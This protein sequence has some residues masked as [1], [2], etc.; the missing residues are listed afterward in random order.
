MLEGY[1][2]EK[3]AREE[4]GLPPLPLNAEQV[5]EI[6]NVFEQGK[7]SNDLLDLLE[8]E[9]PPGVDEAAY[10][11]AAFLKDI[12]TEKLSTDLISPE[13]AI[14]LILL[15]DAKG[16]PASNPKPLTMLTTPFG[17]RSPIISI[18]TMIDAGVCSAGFNTTQL[19]AANAGAS[20]QVA[21]SNGK[22][23]GIICP[24]TPSGSGI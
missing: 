16:L 18:I 17:K 20:F 22:F 4:Q 10:V 11:K 13:K 14:F 21:I 3:I 15:E 8:N 24:T 5:Q 1:Y 19:P 7:G 6:A 12:A 23:Q 2:K 9:V